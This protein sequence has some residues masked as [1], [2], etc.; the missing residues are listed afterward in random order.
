LSMLGSIRLQRKCIDAK[1]F[2]ISININFRFT[3]AGHYV[4]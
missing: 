4:E 1:S 2:S 3:A